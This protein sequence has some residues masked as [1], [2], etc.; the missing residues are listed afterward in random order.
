MVPEWIRTHEA[1]LLW[2]AILSVATFVGTLCVIP[3]LVV[4]IPPEYFADDRRDAFRWSKRHPVLGLSVLIAKNAFG[5]IF[6]LSGIAMLF[7]PGQGVITI[8]IG[9]TLMNFPKKRALQRF[10]I[11][12]RSVKRGINWL[13]TKANRPA[14]QLPENIRSVDRQTL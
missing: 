1:A 8:L 4:R 11:Q 6:V 13:R 2:L 9:L 10:I 14:L 5:V 3:L 12:R 7:L